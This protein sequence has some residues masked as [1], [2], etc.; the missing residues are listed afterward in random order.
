MSAD[1]VHT[2]VFQTVEGQVPVDRKLFPAS[3]YTLNIFCNPEKYGWHGQETEPGIY[4]LDLRELGCNIHPRTILDFL[5]IVQSGKVIEIYPASREDEYQIK[6][7][8]HFALLIGAGIHA[9]CP[10]RI[11]MADHRDRCEEIA[12]AEREQMRR[13]NPMTPREDYKQLYDWKVRHVS[14]GGAVGYSVTVQTSMPQGPAAM[15]FYE[16]KLKTVVTTQVI[17]QPP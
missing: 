7:V 1:T 15:Y 10:F 17:A 4:Y 3:S 9:M 8:E 11:A 12:C 14:N 16:R 2:V 6:M 5:R 13:Y